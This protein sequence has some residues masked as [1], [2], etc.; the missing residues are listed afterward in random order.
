MLSESDLY[1]TSRERW[2]LERLLYTW[3]RP[4]LEVKSPIL[5]GL[6][7]R[8]RTLEDLHLTSEVGVRG[9]YGSIKVLG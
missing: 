6:A 2:F 1:L 9:G 7:G 8:L 5:T 3:N 4:I